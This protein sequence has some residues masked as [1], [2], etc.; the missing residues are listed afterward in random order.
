MLLQRIERALDDIRKSTA[1]S[2]VFELLAVE[3]APTYIKKVA[4][5]TTL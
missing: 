2:L 5:V 3:L 1:N 4:S